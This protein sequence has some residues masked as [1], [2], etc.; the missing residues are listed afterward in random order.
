MQSSSLEY[1]ARYRFDFNKWVYQG[2]PFLSPSEEEAVRR[3]RQLESAAGGITPKRSSIV[4]DGD[5]AA[6]IR[7]V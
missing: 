2:I 3:K 1:L 6:F 4:V 7:A 5:N